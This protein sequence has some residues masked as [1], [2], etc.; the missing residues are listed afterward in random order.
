MGEE[1]KAVVGADISGFTTGITKA[2]SLAK[3]FGVSAERNLGIGAF[4]GMVAGALS[5]G[6]VTS[7]ISGLLDKADGIDAISKRFDITAEAVQSIQFAAEQTGTSADSMFS[8]LK[9]LVSKQADAAGGNEKLVA[10]FAK[11][12]VSAEDLK[13]KNV[14]QLFYQ[15]GSKVNGTSLETDKLSAATTLF[16][17][18]GFSVLGAMRDGFADVAKGARDAGVVI[19]NELVRELANAHDVLAKFNA[20]KTVL[21]ANL[22]E[23]G[24][25]AGAKVMDDSLLGWW[26]RAFGALSTGQGFG[27]SFEQ[28]SNMSWRKDLDDLLKADMKK[29]K[30]GVKA[31]EP[32]EIEP[33]RGVNVKPLSLT[34]N[35]QVGAYSA[36]DPILN[37]QVQISEA[38]LEWQK[39]TNAETNKIAKNTEDTVKA[40]IEANDY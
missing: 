18:A 15:I 6:A 25:K 35:Q 19:R 40:L 30:N 17:K 28:A 36:Q 12:G 11:L 5:V 39:K 22:L 31:Q 32:K 38:L 21:T 37:R 33:F 9:K 27:K 8:A 20:K 3:E 34:Q 2:K 7:A 10:A 1:M 23:G 13:S 29:P 4:K 16:G 26:S 24:M 14:E